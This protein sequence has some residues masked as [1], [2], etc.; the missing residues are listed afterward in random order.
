MQRTLHVSP[1]LR[2]PIDTVTQ[3]LVIF[4]GKG[5]GKTNLGS[6]ISEEL[7]ECGLRFSVIDPLGVWWGL[8]HSAD[9]KGK[10][11]DVLILGGRRGDIPI[12]PT[13]GAIVADLVVDEATSVVVDIS[14]WPDGKRWSIGEK[15]RFVTDYTVHLYERQGEKRRPLMQIY[16]EAARFVP[17]MIPHGAIDIAKC[18]G[19]IET[20]TEEG[21]NV[22]LGTCLI[23]QRSARLNKSV[24]ELAECMIA[25]RTIGPNSV[26]A[27]VDWFG[28]H[29]A[30]E[31]WKSL[32][33]TLRAL[34]R[35]EA[36]V[37]SPGWLGFED[38]AKIRKRETYDS[39]ATPRLGVR[40]T[41]PRKLA[42]PELEKYQKRMQATIEEAKTKDPKELQMALAQARKEVATLRAG[43][44]RKPAVGV[45]KPVK[46]QVPVIPAKLVRRLETVV[47]RLDKVGEQYAHDA[48][49]FIEMAKNAIAV[50][51][52][53]REGFLRTVR[54]VAKAVTDAARVGLQPAV[55]ARPFPGSVAVVRQRPVSVPRPMVDGAEPAIGKG[56]RI[57]LAAVAQHAEGVTRGQLTALTGYKRSSRDAYVSRVQARGL[58]EMNSGRVV[59]TDKGVLILGPDHEP[60]PT[61]SALRQHWLGRLPVGQRAVLEVALQVWP[62]WVSRDAVSEKT[63]YKRSSRD[64][65]VSRLCARELLTTD[66]GSIRASDMLF[67]PEEVAALT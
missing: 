42:P 25:F 54:E 12:V 31:R 20:V 13:A 58:V 34:P 26:A 39:S 2:L 40:V 33:E 43:L 27:I 47:G 53:R 55:P 66:R 21:R 8:Q 22:G 65:Y 60:L 38:V 9:G 46:V 7:Y 57:V 3:T 30:K 48:D 49:R 6:V 11:L 63:S 61:G 5:M 28:E 16:D 15:V 32:I 59:V 52:E 56:E 35:G 62:E 17:Q 23:A 24:A 36:L 10:G 50:A 67:D 18:V 64:A 41:A 29:V 44:A 37:V 1:D 4:G 19:A 51:A 14:S 45:A